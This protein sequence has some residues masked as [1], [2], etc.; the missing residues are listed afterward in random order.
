MAVRFYFHSFRG[1]WGGK[2]F[3]QNSQ[4]FK[5]KHKHSV[6]CW[7]R[8]GVRTSHQIR[9][10]NQRVTVCHGSLRDFAKPTILPFLGNQKPVIDRT[11]ASQGECSF[12]H[13]SP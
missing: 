2:H 13:I 5:V 7:F 10:I 1:G 11:R 4:G 3:E 9:G 12:T 6:K 8:V